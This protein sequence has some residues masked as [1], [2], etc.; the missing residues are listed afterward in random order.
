[1]LMADKINDHPANVEEKRHVKAVAVL[2]D[3]R[4]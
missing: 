2:G 3:F 1:M 4:H